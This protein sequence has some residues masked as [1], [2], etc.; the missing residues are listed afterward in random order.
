MWRQIN[1]QVYHQAYQRQERERRRERRRGRQTATHTINTSRDKYP[2]MCCYINVQLKSGIHRLTGNGLT[3]LGSQMDDQKAVDN[4]QSMAHKKRTGHLIQ[5][6]VSIPASNTTTTT[7]S[8]H[9]SISICYPD[10]LQL[11]SKCHPRVIQP[12][13]ICNPTTENKQL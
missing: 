12:S 2:G 11:L 13:S 8:E 6:Q 9:L 5:M 10:V 3:G 1:L 4:G 7:S